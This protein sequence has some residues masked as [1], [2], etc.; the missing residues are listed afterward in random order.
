M[1]EQF[2]NRA[3]ANWKLLLATAELAG[4]NWPKA[5]RAAAT[6]LSRQHRQEPSEGKRLLAAFQVLFAAHGSMLTSANVQKLLTADPTSE[7]ADF[8]GHGRPINQREIALLLDGYEIH[9]QVIHPRKGKSDRGYRVEW[10]WKAFRHYLQT[11][12]PIRTSVRKP[13]KTPRK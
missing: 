9:P 4:G 2:N 10:F 8:R 1:P 11:L 7:W 3:A 12:P 6:K 5:A 13:R